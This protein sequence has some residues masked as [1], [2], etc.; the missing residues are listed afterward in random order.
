MWFQTDSTTE[1]NHKYIKLIEMK[2]FS[3]V[4]DETPSDE[5]SNF[6]VLNKQLETVTN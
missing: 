1:M 6:H 3:V 2:A 5:G 4:V